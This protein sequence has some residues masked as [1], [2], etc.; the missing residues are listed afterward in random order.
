MKLDLVR[1]RTWGVI[2]FELSYYTTRVSS[3]SV[4]ISNAKKIAAAIYIPRLEHVKQLTMRTDLNV[5]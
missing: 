3:K 5:K 2:S 4:L 1:W